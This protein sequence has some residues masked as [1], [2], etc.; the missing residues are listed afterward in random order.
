MIGAAWQHKWLV[1]S[2]VALCTI[3]ATVFALGRPE[4]HEASASIVFE[5]TAGLL[6]ISGSGQS[7]RLVANEL[8]ILRSGAVLERAAE[9]LT[10]AGN[11]DIT[12]IGLRRDVNMTGAANADVIT[13]SY[14]AETPELA[15]DV[16]GAVIQAYQEVRAGHREAESNMSLERLDAAEELLLDD[17]SAVRAELDEA[18]AD[19]GFS[20]MIDTVLNELSAIEAQLLTQLSTEER[21]SLIARQEQLQSQLQALEAGLNIESTRTDIEALLRRESQILNRLSDLEERRS[22]IEIQ[23]STRSSGVAFIS[24]PTVTS[25]ETGAT[26]LLTALAGTVLGLLLALGVS[27]TMSVNRRAFGDRQEPAEVLESPFLADVPRFDPTSAKTNLPVRDNPRAPVAEAFRFAA[28]SLD[29]RMERMDARVVVGVSGL[30]GEGKTAV[31]ANIALAAARAGKRVLVVDADFGNQAMSKLLLN[32]FRMGPGLTEL[33]AGKALLAEAA[34]PVSLGQGSVL[35]LIS[36]G[37]EPAS[38]PTVLSSPDMKAIIDR[39]TDRYDL[40][41]LDGPPLT[42]VA[43]GSALARLADVALVIVAHGSAIHR[44]ADLKRQLEI[45][46][47]PQAGYVYNKAP[48]RPEMLTSGGSM[49]DVIGDAGATEPLPAE[50]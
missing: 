38:A 26:R 49:K 41:F 4:R 15:E 36:R 19:R 32:N 46:D 25:G 14:A 29:L 7:G 44:A 5:D 33:V 12:L 45:I 22:E 28:S 6:G 23:Q 47:I 43:Y 2:I 27:Y 8:E 30:V 1:V 17:L 48:I 20:L 37:R 34:V 3:A 13:I 40:V 39:M 24:P 11:D 18:R 9:I 16:A 21:T 50:S 35:H 31:L 10:D 42:Q